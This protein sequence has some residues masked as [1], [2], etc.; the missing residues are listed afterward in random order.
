MISFTVRMRFRPQDRAT[1]AGFLRDLTLAS[2]TE[3]GCVSYVAHSVEADP[4]T[5]LIYEQYRD[6]AA[7]EAHRATPHFERWATNGFYP[8]MQER[9]F[10]QLVAFA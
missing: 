6:A 4:D 8:L 7:L 1:V 2:R 5:V 10:E 9:S 3:P